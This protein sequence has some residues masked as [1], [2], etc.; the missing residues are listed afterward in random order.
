M[1]AGGQEDKE[2]GRRGAKMQ[3]SMGAKGRGGTREK[4]GNGAK[5][6]GP[7]STG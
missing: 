2:Q 6:M 7:E 5:Q 4:Q 1:R 3:R